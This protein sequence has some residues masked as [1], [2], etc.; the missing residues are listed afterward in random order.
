[1]H[2]VYIGMQQAAA[3]KCAE[4][5]HHAA[6]TMY[7]FHVVKRSGRGNLTQLWHFARQTVDILLVEIELGF[8]GSSKQMQDG[9]GGTTHRNVECHRIFECL[10][11]CDRTRQYRIVVLFVI[12][13][14][15][16]DN[17]TASL[18][19]QLFTIGMSGKQ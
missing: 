19:E 4:N 7:V 10:E 17:G 11:A 13:F 1:M 5:A 16:L 6:R 3:L 8:L 18:E 15:E 9:V 12:T 2:C 14:A